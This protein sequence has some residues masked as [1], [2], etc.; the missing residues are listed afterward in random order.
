M[1]VEVEGHFFGERVA[2]LMPVLMFDAGK[3]DGQP[4]YHG[5]ARYRPTLRY[6]QP[7]HDPT[8]TRAYQEPLRGFA[9][10]GLTHSRFGRWPVE[11]D[12][13]QRWHRAVG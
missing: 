3:C 10:V 2:A 13:P 6:P 5:A 9:H 12:Q 8:E 7:P 1:P 4:A 11:T